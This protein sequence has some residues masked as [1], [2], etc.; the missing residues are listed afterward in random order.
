[1]AV[2]YK[3]DSPYA[4]NELLTLKWQELCYKVSLSVTRP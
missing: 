1:M 2:Q 3:N 4:N